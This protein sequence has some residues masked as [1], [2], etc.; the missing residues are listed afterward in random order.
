MGFYYGKK[1]KICTETKMQTY[2]DYIIEGKIANPIAVEL[3]MSKL[4]SDIGL[5]QKICI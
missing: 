2:E 4:G 3:N 5:A 1:R